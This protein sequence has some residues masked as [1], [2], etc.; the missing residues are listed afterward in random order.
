MKQKRDTAAV[1][2]SQSRF[3]VHV[4]EKDIER[5]KR[6]DS[7][8]CV[9]AQAIARTVPDATRIE[10]DNQTI[11]FT[12]PGRRLKFLT[13]YVVAGYVVAFDAGD[14][15]AP[16][17]FQLRNPIQAAKKTYTPVGR[18]IHRA[19]NVARRQ[20]KKRAKVAG[21]PLDSPE[22]TAQI[23]ESA[24]A[25]YAEAVQAN[26]G[27]QSTQPGR[28]TAVRVFKKKQRSYGHRLLRINQQQTAE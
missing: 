7:Y 5:A 19:R 9:V 3:N 22:V 27:Q 26:P 28:I 16:F 15:I 2:E 11:R 24:T 23:R 13:P 17:S 10:V 14:P 18:A 12:R 4:T 8:T 1:K 20:A 6:N 21:L 25:A